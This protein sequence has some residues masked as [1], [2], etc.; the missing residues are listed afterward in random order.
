MRALKGAPGGAFNESL[1]E[2]HQPLALAARQVVRGPTP[3]APQSTH[4]LVREPVAVLEELL[5]LICIFVRVR[6]VGRR[7]NKGAAGRGWGRDGAVHAAV[8]PR[9]RGA[10]RTPPNRAPGACRAITFLEEGLK[11]LRAVGIAL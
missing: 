5:P 10:L 8:A 3:P 2:T 6:A 1:A 11:N 7:C 4:L 9:C